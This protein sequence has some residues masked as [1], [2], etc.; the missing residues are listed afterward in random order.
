MTR[1]ITTATATFAACL[2]IAATFAVAAPKEKPALKKPTMGIQLPEKYNTPDGMTL[3][4]ERNI[5]LSMPNFNDDSHPAKLLKISKRN[6]VSEF[7]TMPVHPDTGKACPLGIDFA[8][9]GH[10]YVADCQAFV[11][12]DYKSRLLRVRIE[13]GKAV[14]CEVLVTGFIMANAVAGHRDCVYVTETVIDEEASPMPSGVYRFKLEELDAEKPIELARGG[15]D[16]HLI[17]TIHTENEEWKVGA[18]GLGFD[19][20]GTMY[21]CNFGDA[22]LNKVT[23][24]PCGAVASNEVLAQGQGMLCCDGL[25]VDPKSGDVFIADFL[26]NAVHRVC[27]KTG[28]VATIAK[29]DMTDGAGGLLDRP[30]EVRR[31]GRRL[32]VANIDLP[33]AENTY[34]KPHSISVIK[35]DD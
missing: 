4:S 16:K 7:F 33:L 25:N 11:D 21:V 30:S 12:K 14:A 10:L 28:K 5:I 22:A 20:K 24:K 29:N 2:A 32:Y 15:K 23:F 34:D 17:T 26:G 9:D 13:D 31:R 8:A 6:E 18:N 3:D 19:K 27:A 1:R 35:L